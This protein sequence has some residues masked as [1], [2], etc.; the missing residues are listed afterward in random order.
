[1][2]RVAWQAIVHGVAKSQ[3]RLNYQHISTIYSLSHL[4]FTMTHEVRDTVSLISCIRY[5]GVK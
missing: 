2:D 3:T 4:T 5:I 1:M